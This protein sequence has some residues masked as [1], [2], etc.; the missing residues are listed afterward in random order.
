MLRII[1]SVKQSEIQ[2]KPST[3]TPLSLLGRLN[4]KVS[5]TTI[6]LCPIADT[7]FPQYSFTEGHYM[8]KPSL[9]LL[10]SETAEAEVDIVSLLER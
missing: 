1:S 6:N 8:I 7:L 9:N 4:Q 5:Q 3:A 2:Q 10:F